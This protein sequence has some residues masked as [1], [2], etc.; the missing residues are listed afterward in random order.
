[1]RKPLL[2]M[3]I[4]LAAL[5]TACGG[6]ETTSGDIGGESAAVDNNPIQ[7]DRS[8]DTIVFRADVVG[9][10]MVGTPQ[11]QSEIPACTIYGDNRVVWT[12]YTSDDEIQVLYDILADE[13]IRSFVEYLVVGKRFFEYDAEASL[14]SAS[15]PQPVVETLFLN[16]NN[17]PHLTDSFGGWDYDYYVEV[18]RFC[19]EISIAPV[20][21]EPSGAWVAAVEVPYSPNTPSIFWDP[22]ANGIDLAALAASGEPMWVT[23]APLQILWHRFTTSLPGTRFDQDFISY[24]IILQVP[25]I[26]RTSPPAPEGA[27]GEN[28]GG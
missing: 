8:P 18:L 4:L 11:E 28:P 19:R 20:I 6:N 10:D 2:G 26:S 23:G 16:V 22:V 12:T 24:E 25:G 13:V 21:Y 1:M 9:G 7:W 5:I 14:Q 15:G 17:E 27:S 3:M